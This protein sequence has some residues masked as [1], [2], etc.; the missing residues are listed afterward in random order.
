LLGGWW[1]TVPLG[2]RMAR[3]QPARTLVY[4]PYSILK[5][6]LADIKI[7]LE[8]VRLIGRELLG[9]ESGVKLT[10]NHTIPKAMV[11]WLRSSSSGDAIADYARWPE[12]LQS[13]F[14]DRR[15]IKLPVNSNDIYNKES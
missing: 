10:H 15:F 1:Y 13:S 9:D 4:A 3:V 12:I 5:A 11:E 7:D 6:K 14:G 2:N 8:L